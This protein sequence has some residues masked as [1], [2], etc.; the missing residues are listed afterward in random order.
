M[1]LAHYQKFLPINVAINHGHFIVFRLLNK[2][3]RIGIN[4]FTSAE[5]EN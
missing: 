1:M 3:W 5:L 2:E 4:F